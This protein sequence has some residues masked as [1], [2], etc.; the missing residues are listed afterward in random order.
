VTTL[1]ALSV[2]SYIQRDGVGPLGSLAPAAGPYVDTY[3][4]GVLSP[5]DVLAVVEVVNDHFAGGAEGEQADAATDA[6][7]VDQVAVEAAP[8]SELMTIEFVSQ[9]VEASLETAS[10][11]PNVHSVDSYFAANNQG[12]QVSARD[13]TLFEDEIT[14]AVLGDH[15]VNEDDSPGE[16]VAALDL[17]AALSDIAADVS[18]AMRDDDE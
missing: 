12:D 2:I 10:D 7:A 18:R 8:I 17:E 6:A 16:L 11:A 1:D 13:A 9:P 14:A 4:D 3:R 5:M 15:T